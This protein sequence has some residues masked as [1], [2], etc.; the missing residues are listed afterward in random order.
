MKYNGLDITTVWVDLDDTLIDFTTNAHSAL[1]R[2]W[3]DESCLQKLFPS[4]GVWAELYER[5]NMALWALYNVGKI[6]RGHLRMERFRLPLAEAGMPDDE[7]RRTSLRFDTLYLDYLAQEK[8][9]RPG[10]IE[11]LQ[12]LRKCNVNIGILSNGFKEVQFRKIKTAGLE[13]YIDL[14]VLSDDIGINKPDIRIYRHAMQQ[15]GDIN[16]HHHLMIGDNPDTDIA[17][18]VRAGWAAIWY[19]PER[20]HYSAV[21][22]DGATM[23]SELSQIPDLAHLQAH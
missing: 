15:T 20:A 14:V 10:A 11:L 22:P 7:A 17:G 5:H 18:A 21:C 19:R 1:V 13:P 4:P 23:V 16:P 2:M 8:N 6:T 12:W 3:H 9:L